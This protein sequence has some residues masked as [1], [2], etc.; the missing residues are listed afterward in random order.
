[1]KDF[2][3][4]WRAWDGC[5]VPWIGVKGLRTVEGLRWIQMILDGC[6]GPGICIEGFGGYGGPQMGVT[7]LGWV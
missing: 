4:V 7:G 2:G 6:V 1:M 5:E 3:W